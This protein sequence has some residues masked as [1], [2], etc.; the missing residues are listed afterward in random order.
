M[1]QGTLR[2][3]HKRNRLNWTTRPVDVEC[4][5]LH[6]PDPDKPSLHLL[7]T[8]TDNNRIVVVLDDRNTQRLTRAL[9]RPIPHPH[10]GEVPR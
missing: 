7:L 5:R 6:T 8:D 2:N 4:I 3:W 10:S 1:I 9:T